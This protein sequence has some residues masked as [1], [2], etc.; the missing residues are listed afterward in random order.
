[1]DSALCVVAALSELHRAF[2]DLLRADLA[3]PPPPPPPAGG[4][5]QRQAPG[6]MHAAV[7]CR[8]LALLLALAR[9]GDVLGEHVSMGRP[10]GWRAARHGGYGGGWRREGRG[11]R[12][13]GGG[14]RGEGCGGRGKRGQ[15]QEGAHACMKGAAVRHEALVGGGCLASWFCLRA[16]PDCAYIFAHGA[17]TNSACPPAY[18]AA[19]SACRPAGLGSSPA[20][21]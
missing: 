8:S 2:P 5:Q 9:C 1:M 3:P 12:G 7:R 4:P 13:A 18:L 19:S 20:A 14:V 21:L 10:G 11:G 17:A 16:P 15:A 6:L